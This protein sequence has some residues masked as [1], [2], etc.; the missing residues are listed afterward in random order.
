MD[1]YIARFEDEEI[2]L[3]TLLTMSEDDLST[4]G[5]A[6]FGP[7]RRLKKGKRIVIFI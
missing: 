3:A 6:K 7:R 1:A 4:L 5:V 2:D